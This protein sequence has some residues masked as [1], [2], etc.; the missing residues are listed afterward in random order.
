MIWNMGG[1]ATKTIDTYEVISYT[2]YFA[3]CTDV[4]HMPASHRRCSSYAGHRVLI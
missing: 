3:V 2:W 1:Q 4:L